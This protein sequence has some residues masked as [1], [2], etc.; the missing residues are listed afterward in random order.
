MQALDYVQKLIAYGYLNG[1]SPA[2]PKIYPIKADAKSDSKAASAAPSVGSAVGG[3]RKLIDV[4]IETVY[5]CSMFEDD[6]VQ[7]QVIKAL[8]TA[9]SSVSCQVHDQTLL[10]AVRGCYHIY[11]MSRNPINQTTAKATLTQMLNIV[12][13]RMENYSFQL[14]EL[15]IEDDEAAREQAQ[16]KL[17]ELTRGA[18][19][20]VANGSAAANANA[21]ANGSAAANGSSFSFMNG[22]G[23]AKSG[24]D[25]VAAVVTDLV[26]SVVTGTNTNGAA[27]APT[28]AAP[29]P[30]PTPTATSPP[31][32]Q[33]AVSTAV[34]PKGKYGVCVVC[35]RPAN[36]YC[37]QT[38]V[39]D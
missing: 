2:D 39:R 33:P 10:R 16:A 9:V 21:N 6:A 3:S 27:P 37:I 8:L 19:A 35:K 4:I 26:E 14:H 22:G 18:A 29:A 17:A 11:L 31:P 30:A 15:Q 25:V 20:A 1:N 38:N 12:F 34:L 24:G 23:N 13:Q 32:P 5:E 36:H 28:P 7:L